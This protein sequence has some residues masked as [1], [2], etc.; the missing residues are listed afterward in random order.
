MLKL[1]R[2]LAILFAWLIS[3]EEELVSGIHSVCRGM[4]AKGWLS[5]SI[6]VVQ[7]LLLA[8]TMY[9]VHLDRWFLDVQH[10]VSDSELLYMCR[11]RVGG[12]V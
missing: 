10:R 9:F 4:I 6:V 7:G 2:R 3:R 12:V 1:G 11:E 8:V 5:T